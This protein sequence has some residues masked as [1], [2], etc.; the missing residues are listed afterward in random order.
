[1]CNSY[2]QMTLHEDFFGYSVSAV[3]VRFL[4]SNV[5]AILD[6][7]EPKN[8]KELASFPGTTKFYL[9]QVRPKL[10]PLR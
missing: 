9:S 8:T 6:L 7:P 3:G 5:K 2:L 10:R 4:Q 1:M